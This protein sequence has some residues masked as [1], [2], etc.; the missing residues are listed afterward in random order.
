M[1]SPLLRRVARALGPPVAAVAIRALVRTLSITRDER[2]MAPLWQASAPIIYVVWHC[3]ILVLPALYGRRRARV[4]ASRSNDGDALT[5]YVRRFGL[6]AVR[7]SSSRGGAE[8]LR[9]LARCLKQGHEVVVVPDG[10]RGPAEQ[11]KPGV[12]TLARV[13]GAAIV[14]LALGASRQWRLR[15][16]DAFRVPAPFARCVVRFGDPIYVPRIA[17]RGQEESLRAEVEHA[18]RALSLSVD[19]DAGL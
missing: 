4:L 3:R 15:S 8:A 13:S 7:G 14:P 16:W 5:R 11:A 10:P 19:R 1:T 12:V 2:R 6:E 18:L 9:L 17:D